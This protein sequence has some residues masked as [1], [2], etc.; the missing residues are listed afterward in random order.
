M[1]L[2]T[3]PFGFEESISEVELDNQRLND[4]DAATEPSKV[5]KKRPVL[6]AKLSWVYGADLNES[7]GFVNAIDAPKLIESAMYFKVTPYAFARRSMM[8]TATVRRLLIERKLP[9]FVGEDD[10][11]MVIVSMDWVFGTSDPEKLALLSFN[12]ED[13]LDFAS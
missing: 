4:G 6:A 12:P 2:N 13:Y 7:P 11:L 5:K 3:Y 10:Q 1:K 8:R 9:R